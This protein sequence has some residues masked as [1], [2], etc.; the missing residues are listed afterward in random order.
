MV[1]KSMFDCGRRCERCFY[2][3]CCELAGEA[4]EHFM[5]IFGGEETEAMRDAVVRRAE[6]YRDWMSYE[7]YE[8]GGVYTVRATKQYEVEVSD[9]EP[10]I[11]AIHIENQQFST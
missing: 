2:F 9:N 7:S 11:A 8:D 4:C 6:F 10:G 3:A 1:T 5:E